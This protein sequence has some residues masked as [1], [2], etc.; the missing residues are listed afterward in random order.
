MEIFVNGPFPTM[1]LGVY[2][3]LCALMISIIVGSAVSDYKNNLENF[4]FKPTNAK[5][6][7]YVP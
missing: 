7:A 6:N 4:R 2:Q 1:L 5:K 3:N